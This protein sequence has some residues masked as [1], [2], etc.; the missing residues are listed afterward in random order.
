MKKQS[1]IIMAV[2]GVSGC[3]TGAVELPLPYNE[4][5]SSIKV[6]QL[7]PVDYPGYFSGEGN[8]YSCYYGVHYIKPEEFRPS[9][10]AVLD[11]YLSDNYPGIGDHSVE[12]LRFDIYY[13]YSEVMKTIVPKNVATHTAASGVVHTSIKFEKGMI[14]GCE[15]T[16]TGEFNRSEVEAGS[17]AV[18]KHLDLVIDGEN[19]SFRHVYPIRPEDDENYTV[20]HSYP[21]GPDDEVEIKSW[22]EKSFPSF[23]SALGDKIDESGYL[24]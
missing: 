13:N 5:L 23:L 15:G 3:S 18:V 19:F 20:K 22:L 1:F 24:E 17:P 21:A 8:I 10:V 6:E 2:L 11:Q 4:E 12:V 14:I 7:K 9:S 16:S